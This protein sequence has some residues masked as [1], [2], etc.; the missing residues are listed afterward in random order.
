MTGS[1]T[2]GSPCRRSAAGSLAAGTLEVLRDELQQPRPEPRLLLLWNL[3]VPEEPRYLEPQV[4]LLIAAYPVAG[5]D[6]CGLHQVRLADR[7]D[8]GERPHD[9][10]RH[11]VP[12]GPRLLGVEMARHR[13]PTSVGEPRAA[14]QLPHRDVLSLVTDELASRLVHRSLEGVHQVTDRSPT[15]RAVAHPMPPSTT[16]VSP[17]T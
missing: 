11:V 12:I 5:R 15:T 3:L 1:R 10:R 7:K 13:G 4:P 8:R 17:T 6:L 16:Y 9:V 2:R 14:D